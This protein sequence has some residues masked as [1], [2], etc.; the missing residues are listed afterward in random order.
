MGTMHHNAIIVTSW[1]REKLDEAHKTAIGL[2]P[3]VSGMVEGT[4]NGQFSFA[5]LP[6]GSKEEWPESDVADS[7]R[8]ALIKWINSQAYEDGSN[9]LE[10]AEISFGDL[11]PTINTN[12][13]N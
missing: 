5:V 6:D 13:A 3:H 4:I 11:D 9:C 7:A 10:Y 8:A 2:M 12:R 1:N